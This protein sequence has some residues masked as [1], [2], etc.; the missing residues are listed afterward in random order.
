MEFRNVRALRGPNIWGRAPVLEVVVDLGA[1]DRPIGQLPGLVERLT[2]WLPALARF[3]GQLPPGT[4][5]GSVLAEVALELQAQA[6][7]P[8][9]FAHSNGTGDPAVRC[10][11]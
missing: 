1:L 11:V 4:D 6:G 9:T 2:D 7:H 3:L 5:L 10:V 8:L